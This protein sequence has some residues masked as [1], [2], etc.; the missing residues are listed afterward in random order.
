MVT[1]IFAFEYSKRCIT[2]AILFKIKK[3]FYPMVIWFDP[4]ANSLS[5]C[6]NTTTNQVGSLFIR[7]SS[8][9]RE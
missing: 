8:P 4:L 9:Y 7:S 5:P 3:D 1:Y 2:I 6:E